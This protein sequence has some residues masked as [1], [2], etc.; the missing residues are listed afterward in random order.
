MEKKER[1]KALIAAGKAKAEDAELLE[2]ASDAVLNFLEV[3]EPTIQIPE[4]HILKKVGDVMVVEPKQAAEPKKAPTEEEY[5][6]AAPDSVKTIVAQHK[7]ATAAR[8]EQLLAA[9]KATGQDAFGEDELKVMSVEQLEKVARVAAAKVPPVDHTG[10]GGPRLEAAA[11]D[12]KVPKP[13]S[14]VERMRAA[15]GAKGAA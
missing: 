15:R 10:R 6:A 8:K 11:E 12:Q 4:T 9:I 13:P 1:I 3:K 5:L 14:I 2:K 7:A